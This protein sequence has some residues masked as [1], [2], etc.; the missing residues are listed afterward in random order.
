MENKNI[1]M[2][3]ISCPLGC[4]LEVKKVGDDYEV[5]GNKC[6]KGKEYAIQEL[7]NPMRGLTST[8][9]S[10]FQDIPRVPV[11]TDKEIPLQDIFLFMEEI[12]SV[13]LEKRLKPGPGYVSKQQGG[14]KGK[15]A[16][17]HCNKSH[18]LASK[19]CAGNKNSQ[20]A[21]LQTHF[22]GDGELVLFCKPEAPWDQK[23]SRHGQE[24]QHECIGDQH[25]KMRIHSS[26]P[27]AL[28]KYNPG[29]N[30]QKQQGQNNP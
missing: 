16:V 29:I 6:K 23:T 1:V 26:I 9:K 12:N 13:V 11:K 10:V 27:I 14:K 24:I 8:V 2:T 3:C 22:N 20:C 28:Q 7:T 18:L 19:Q 30:S 17:Y 5:L 25:E 21:V 4:T 15:R